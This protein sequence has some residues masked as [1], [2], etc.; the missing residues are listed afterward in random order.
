MSQWLFCRWHSATFYFNPDEML[1][2]T[3]YAAYDPSLVKDRELDYFTIDWYESNKR[4]L[5]KKTA[6][7]I[8]ISIKRSIPVQSLL[9]NDILVCDDRSAILIAVKPCKCIIV[10]PRNAMELGTVCY[11]IGNKHIPV[12]LTE[13]EIVLPFDRPT[14]LLLEKN[15]FDLKVEERI[16]ENQLRS[17]IPQHGH[18]PDS[19]LEKII[20]LT[21]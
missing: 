21:T 12:S 8:D 3:I 16:F 6:K 1:L 19:L 13:T 9:H 15:G 7:G 2:N 4:I 18:Q 10:F 20:K 11:D 17:N 14:F 5:R